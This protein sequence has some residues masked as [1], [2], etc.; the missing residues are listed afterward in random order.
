MFCNCR[1]EKGSRSKMLGLAAPKKFAQGSQLYAAGPTF[2]GSGLFASPFRSQCTR[3]PKGPVF[4]TT[5]SSVPTPCKYSLSY[6]HHPPSHS[7]PFSLLTLLDH[8]IELQVLLWFQKALDLRLHLYPNLTVACAPVSY[9][10]NVFVFVWSAPN[11]SSWRP[12]STA[13]PVP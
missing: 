5:G 13:Q 8:I 12:P 11:P 6:H 10:D 3:A 2:W 7:S 4:S 1:C 9:S